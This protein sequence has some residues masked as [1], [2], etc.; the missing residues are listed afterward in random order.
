MNKFFGDVASSSMRSRLF[1]YSIIVF[2]V[3]FSWTGYLDG[4]ATEYVDGAVLQSTLAFG[5]AKLLNGLI[6]VAQSTEVQISLGAGMSIAI[7]EA[8]DPFNDLVEQY[9]SM[10]KLSIGSLIIQKLL[11]EITSDIFFKSMLTL[12][13]LMM[14][15]AIHYR[16]TLYF[17]LISKTF[18]FMLFVRY[19]IVL[20]LFLNGTVDKAFIEPV[21]EKDIGALQAVSKQEEAMQLQAQHDERSKV[22]QQLN[23]DREERVVIERKLASTVSE[24][25]EINQKIVGIDGQ[26]KQ[27]KDEKSL[28]ANLTQKNEKIDALRAEQEK[29][30]EQLTVLNKTYSDLQDKLDTLDDQI[31]ENQ[32]ILDGKSNGV[33]SAIGNGISK[34]GSSVSSF[35]DADKILKLKEGLENTATNMINL[36]AL[37]IFKTLILP[38]FF[39]YLLIKGTNGIW[40]IDIRQKITDAKDELLSAPKTQNEIDSLR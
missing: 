39:L 4:Q 27:I 16:L 19:A 20:A 24:K 23:N 7:G 18:I 25:T 3:I 32:N 6:S 10:M 28:W 26:I 33:F 30:D 2:A 36:M 13:A 1:L 31:Q 34:M 37:F 8:L 40:Q 22:E 9:S 17:G 21:S 14:I 29:Y 38:L 11:I 35:F 15:L 5:V 12:S